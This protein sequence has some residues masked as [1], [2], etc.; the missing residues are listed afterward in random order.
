MSAS[1]RILAASLLLLGATGAP[2]AAADS[3]DFILGKALFERLWVQAPSSTKSADGLGPLFNARACST[4]HKGGG[5]TA[6]ALNGGELPATSS[7]TLRVGQV[8]D[9]KI[10]PHPQLGEQVQTMAVTALPS[11]GRLMVQYETH[12]VQ[13][14]DGAEVELRKPHFL[15]ANDAGKM[16]AIDW[17]SPRLAQDLHGLGLLERIPFARMAELADPDD[18]DGDGI[19]GAVVMGTYADDNIHPGRFGWKA[20][21][22][23]LER[24]A[25]SAFHLDIGLSTPTHL[26][27]WGDCTEAETKCRALPHGAKAG[28]PEVNAQ[29]V[30]LIANFLRELPAPQAAPPTDE[31]RAGAAIFAKAG[32]GACHTERQPSFDAAGTDIWIAPYSDLLVHDMGD[33]LADQT[34]SGALS[35]ANDAREWRTAPLWGLGRRAA[36]GPATTLLHD[37]RA[38]S[39]LE[40]IL[41]HG[42]EAA[43]ARQAAM[44]LSAEDRAKLI[45]FLESL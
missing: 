36:N 25:S 41:W 35:A 23:D 20:V 21:E 26:E 40:A 39:I 10:A 7:L 27:P 13:L 32:C 31:T 24:Q 34:D 19:S 43:K 28:E 11:E 30:T 16:P 3:M 6:V 29:L 33:G 45:A 9:G 37:G 14:A 44:G 22:P 2:A 1:P 4:C 5:Q 18:L 42:G 38:R 8:A 15:I 12:R 17:V